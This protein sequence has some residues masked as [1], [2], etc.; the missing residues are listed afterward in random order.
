MYITYTIGITYIPHILCELFTVYTLYHLCIYGTF[1]V[2]YHI[3]TDSL[4]KTVYI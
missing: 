2:S 3:Y 4:Y 1:S